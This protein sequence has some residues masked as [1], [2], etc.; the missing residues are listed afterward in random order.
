VTLAG[1]LPAGLSV[2]ARDATRRS[3]TWACAEAGVDSIEHGFELD[4]DV[5][6]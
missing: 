3:G 5:P 6:S 2:E 1:V 4:A